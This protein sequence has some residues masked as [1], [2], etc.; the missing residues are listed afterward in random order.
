MT[1]GNPNE[2]YGNPANDDT[3]R[4]LAAVALQLARLTTAVE[5]LAD[6][7]PECAHGPRVKKTGSNDRGDWSGWFCPLGQD[8]ADERC[9]PVFDS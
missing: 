1:A 2:I 8:R 3:T 6:K 9:S 4:M 7:P 5:K